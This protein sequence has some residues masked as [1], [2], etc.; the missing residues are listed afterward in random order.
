MNEAPLLLWTYTYFVSGP[1]SR[2]TWQ[3][4]AILKWQSL[5]KNH[6]FCTVKFCI[7][8]DLPYR[9]QK[10]EFMSSDMC[11]ENFEFMKP[12]LCCTVCTHNQ[13]FSLVPKFVESTWNRLLV[14][15]SR[16]T[17]YWFNSDCSNIQWSDTH[18]SNRSQSLIQKLFR[19]CKLTT[20]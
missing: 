10:V 6:Q 3:W 11:T 16:Y 18:N 8:T 2:H 4:V 5:H 20:P 15:Y 19:D 9:T 13:R 7:Y 17:F 1:L 12:C 14:S